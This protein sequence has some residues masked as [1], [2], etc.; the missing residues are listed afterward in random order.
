VT[1]GASYANEVWLA[2][3]FVVRVNCRGVGR[4]RREG[5]IAARVVRE[6]LYPAIRTIG[7]DGE[8]EWMITTRVQ[9]R[10]LGRAW[11][12][13]TPSQ[14]E[15]ATR[16]LCDA[17]AALHATPTGGLSEDIEPPHTLPLAPLLALVR[18][19]RADGG[20]AALLD[21]VAAFVETRWDALDDTGVGLVHGDPHL[22]NVLWDGAHV[23]ALL[24]LEWSR[25]SWIECDL[26]I[27]LAIAD[28]PQLFAS[29]DHQA[30]VHTADYAALPRWV[31]AAQ[32]SWFAHPR[33]VDRLEVLHV[34]R[35]LGCLGSHPASPAR[36]QHLRDVLDG[37]SY[38]RR[39]CAGSLVCDPPTAAP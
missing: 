13:L 20:D 37:T 34:S 1:R 14:R 11:A 25:R 7:D 9:G 30:S 26:E 10:E 28:H 12:S 21:E 31:A 17:L 29:A 2:D 19:V 6:A 16:E 3:D 38:L 22:E 33:L 32:P 39:Q 5:A 27:L 8:L 15:R 24:D 4:L 35:T 36:W 23:T 18:D